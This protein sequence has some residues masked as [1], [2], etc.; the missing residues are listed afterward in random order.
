MLSVQVIDPQ[1]R[2]VSNASVRFSPIK[3]L[4]SSGKKS[5]YFASPEKQTD[6][7]GRADF[8]DVPE[9]FLVSVC[10]RHT[11]FALKCSDPIDLKKLGDGPAVVLFRIVRAETTPHASAF[12]LGA[13]TFRLLELLETDEPRPWRR[14]LD[15]LADRFGV[16]IPQGAA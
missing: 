12:I 9:G 8:D 15:E 10:A 4:L 13:A 11:D 3:E 14:V 1:R 6:E 7:K 2:P 5:I 16:A